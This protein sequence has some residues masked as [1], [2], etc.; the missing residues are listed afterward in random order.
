MDAEALIRAVVALQEGLARRDKIDMPAVQA[1]PGTLLP[2]MRTLRQDERFAFDMLLD[3]TAIDWLQQGRIE[4]IYNLYSTTRGHY[5]MV[6]VSL[7]RIAPVA[8]TVSGIWEIAQWQERE[9]YDL[10]G[11]RYDDHP[12][13]RRL[14]L[15]DDWQG[16]P[17]RKDYQDAN[18]LECPR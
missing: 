15:D 12:D 3:H 2:L 10:F 9:V 13:L 16:H 5:L 17:L 4:L 11:V 7:P 8:P 6:S 14:F 1:P 18:M